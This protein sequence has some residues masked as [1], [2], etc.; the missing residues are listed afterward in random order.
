MKPQTLVLDT[1]DDRREIR[2]LLS[3]LPP[4]HRIRFLEWACSVVPQGQR[5]LPV[6]VVTD[7]RITADQAYRCDHADARL[8][9]EVYVDI[10]QLFHQYELDAA[11]TARELEAWVKRPEYRKARLHALL[12]VRRGLEPASPGA[13]PSRTGGS[14]TSDR[15]G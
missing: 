13:G 10:L 5:R 7:M 14:G 12:R 9:D 8:T 11:S 2:N 15:R 4:P 1:N 6:P 3:R